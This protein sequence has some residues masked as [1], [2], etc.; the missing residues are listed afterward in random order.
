MDF[1][2]F[3]TNEHITASG[4]IF[5]ER[6]EAVSFLGGVAWQIELA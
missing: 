3:G 6:Y 5:N 1:P 4:S 2:L